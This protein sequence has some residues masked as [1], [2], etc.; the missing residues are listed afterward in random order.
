[1]A[2]LVVGQSDRLVRD[3]RAAHA[4]ARNASTRAEV[5]RPGGC[6]VPIGGCALLRAAPRAAE[7]AASGVGAGGV[8]E[9]PK[10]LAP[11]AVR[12]DP[13]FRMPLHADGEG[14]AL[15]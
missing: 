7:L 3:R 9:G 15:A 12:V 5:R 4:G 2:D 13:V 1:M 11:K 8:A 14:R 6:R 10:D